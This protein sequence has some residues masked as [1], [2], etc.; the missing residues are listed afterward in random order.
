ML[1]EAL[2]PEEEQPYKVPDNWVWTNIKN[3]ADVKGGKRLPKGDALVAVKTDHPYLRVADFKNGSIDENDIKYITKETHANISR[4]T[5][6][7]ED[8]YISIAGTIGKVGLIPS[9]LDGANLTENAAKITNIRC[10][11][12]TFL[13]NAL[14]SKVVNSQI[15]SAIK[16]TSQ[17]KL[18]IHRIQDLKIPLP[19]INEQKRIANKVER[20]LSKID[21]AKQLID[22]AKETFEL[23]R[24]AILDKAFRGEFSN[25][26]SFNTSKLNI[27]ESKGS[28]KDDGKTEEFKSHLKTLVPDHWEIH[29]LTDI[30][31]ET[32]DICYGIV[33][34]G[35]DTK[36]GIPTFRA[37]DLKT[38]IINIE[39]L[40]KVTPEIEEKYPRSRLKGYEVLISIRGSVG[41]IARSTVGMIGYNVSREIAIIPI[42]RTI[43]QC[44]L[45]YYLQS[46]LVQNFFKKITK[47]VAQSGI[48]LNQLR[49]LP[50]AIPSLEEQQYIVN[51]IEFLIQKEQ[52]ALNYLNAER[53]IIQLSNSI[54][55]KAFRGELGTNDP[56]EESSIKLLKEVLQEQIQ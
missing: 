21:D 49:G 45:E 51:K 55:Y 44:F 11:D 2:V 40:K 20:L 54:L 27:N 36:D 19:P 1:E 16:A 48:N 5:I 42:N 56:T 31:E 17:P 23:R 8:V 33:Q 29:P 53:R 35:A 41:Y 47:G 38:D 4:Y 25:S 26:S 15:N 6:A 32:R 50:I 24:A 10:T 18:A 28:I 14:D 7:S 43:S 3:L 9:S 13:Y 12:K 46:P 34:T 30:L 39:A 52:K 22:E 37:G